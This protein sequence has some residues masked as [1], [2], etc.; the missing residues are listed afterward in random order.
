MLVAG[1]GLGVAVCH[2]MENPK[3]A[4]IDVLEE[5]KDVAY[6]MLEHIER[7][8]SGRK[9]VNVYIAEVGWWLENRSSRDAPYT[10]AIF[11]VQPT[12]ATVRIDC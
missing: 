7:I 4:T 11:N 8:N 6:L 2:L 10:Y 12:S 3:V 5:Q 9:I 1:L